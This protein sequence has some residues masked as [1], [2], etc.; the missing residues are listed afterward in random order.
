LLDDMRTPGSPTSEVPAWLHQLDPGL[1]LSVH[2]GSDRV[3]GLGISP[4]DSYCDQPY[5]YCSPYPALASARRPDLTF[6]HRRSEEFTS[7]V[8]TAKEMQDAAPQPA[9]VVAHHLAG[10]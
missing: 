8:S 1:V 10:P 9:D 6:G 5:F 2:V 4:D 3:I 7:A